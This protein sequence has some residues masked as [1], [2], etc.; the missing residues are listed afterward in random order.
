VRQ[1]LAD[2]SVATDDGVLS[3]TFDLAALLQFFDHF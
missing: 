1:N 3:H 2:P